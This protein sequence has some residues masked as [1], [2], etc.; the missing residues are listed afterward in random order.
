MMREKNDTTMMT[1]TVG[2]SVLPIARMLRTALKDLYEM[3][4]EL[5]G[6]SSVVTERYHR[7]MDQARVAMA[8]SIG[9]V[10]Q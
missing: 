2:D 3:Q 6:G 9:I 5:G 1:G 8:N 10:A 7:V 4:C